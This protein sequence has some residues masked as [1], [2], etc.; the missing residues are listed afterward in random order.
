ESLRVAPGYE[1][2]LLRSAE[3][4]EG[5]WI[6]LAFD[7]RGRFYLSSED[8]GKPI[9]RGTLNATGNLERLEAVPAPLG[10]AMGIL[11]AHDSLYLNARG[12]EGNGLYRLIDRNGNDRFDTNEW[13]LLKA[14]PTGGEHGYHALALGPEGRIY[15][16]NG[17]M[18]RPPEGLSSHSPY[19]HF[20]DDVLSLN[21][22]ESPTAAGI[23][24]PAGYIVRT[25]PEGLEW[26]L[27]LGGLRNAYGFDFSPDGE[28][29]TFDSDN[30][31]NWGTPWYVPTRILHGVSG[32][33]YGWRDGVRIWPEDQPESLPPVLNVGIGSPCGVRF[34]TRGHFPER[35]RR[36][37]FVQDWS[38]GRILAVH[39]E[40][41][42]ASYRGSFEEFLSGRPLNLTAMDFGPDGALYFITG[43]R[44]TQSGLYRVRY[45]GELANPAAP[46]PPAT[47]PGREARALRHRLEQFHGR[48]H[49]DALTEAWPHLGSGDPF[50][51]HAARVAVEAQPVATWRERAL[52]EP[53]ASSGLTALLALARTGGP[54]DQPALLAA[55]ARF[56][57]AALNAGQRQ[58]K[59]RVLQVSLVRQ[60]RPE[61]ASLAATLR[62]LDPHFPTGSWPLNRD[63]ARVLITLE[64]PGLVGR[65]LA[66]IDATTLPEEQM[67]FISQ[68]RHVRHGWTLD[69]RRRYFQWWHL[70][71]QPDRHPPDLLRW[72][73]D[74]DRSYVDG[75]SVDR[76]LTEMHRD[77]VATL[78]D[79]ERGAL[80]LLIEQPIAPAL[81]LPVSPREFVQEWTFEELLPHLDE[82]SSGRDFA[83]ARQAWIDIQ[84]LACH[85]MGNEGGAI[86]PE[87][88]GVGSKYTRRD[89]LESILLPSKVVSEQF[90]NVTVDLADGDDVTGRLI[91]ET[92]NEV[93]IETDWRTGT[94]T[95]VSRGDLQRMRPANLSP[96]PEGLLSVLTR[97]EILDL[98]AYLESG[99]NADAPA[100]R[101]VPRP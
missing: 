84:C 101:K 1:V 99:G 59:L 95:T 4:A 22:D 62:D 3:P 91:S 78:T 65:T 31:W 39:L 73:A 64:A 40:P 20:S 32:A 12:P 48:P 14:F 30:E 17:N 57:F 66:L 15:V 82:A 38:Y 35:H 8:A 19:R 46:T 6:C 24:A 5:S 61:P 88:S 49:P 18:T 11:H 2:E 13:R 53:D 42:G 16:M 50:I 29:F 36:A 89:I 72:F 9:F 86:G 96:M 7:D 69:E 44:G 100:F 55:L 63:L 77:A 21:P 81:L 76:H 47:D 68:L 25:D 79:D 23:K 58:L 87:L 28:L 60:G 70:P 51:R 98:L 41:D 27:F 54:S 80:G 56:P 93:V 34:G 75:A 52:A 90:Q 85:R 45:V 67:F 71:R 83:R 74:V 10:Q 26:D 92:D 43:G 37:L 97:D 33:D 94:R